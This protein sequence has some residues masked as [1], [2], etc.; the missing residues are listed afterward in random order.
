MVRSASS[1]PLNWPAAVWNSASGTAVS[2]TRATVSAQLECR[3]L[4]F[5][6]QI[7]GLAPGRHEDELLDRQAVLKEIAPSSAPILAS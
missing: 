4:L 5:R 3:A 7:A 1:F 2:A 6:E